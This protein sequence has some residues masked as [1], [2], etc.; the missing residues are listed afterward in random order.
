[1]QRTLLSKIRLTL[2]F[3]G[4]ALGALT[5]VAILSQRFGLA[6]TLLL[7]LP[8]TL[9][10]L[11]LL[12][13]F[14]ISAVRPLSKSLHDL[15]DGAD[16]TSELQRAQASHGFKPYRDL[17]DAISKALEVRRD[18]I[19]R[20]VR[21]QR[22]LLNLNNKLSIRLVE[23]KTM[24]TIWRYQSEIQETKTFLSSVLEHLIVGMRFDVGCLFIRPIPK[25]GPHAVFAKL[26]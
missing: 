23:S 5:L 1:M 14:V 3:G 8:L 17:V 4:V 26:N 22:R 2:A 12:R 21:Y 20:L 15:S 11:L 10:E 6:L 25:L 7:A 18:D 9:A 16:P 13:Y 24:L 19:E